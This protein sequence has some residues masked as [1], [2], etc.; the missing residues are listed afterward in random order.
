[1]RLHPKDIKVGD[2]FYECERGMNEKMVCESNPANDG[3][4]WTFDA[5]NEQ[6]RSVNYFYKDSAEAYAP[7][8]YDSPQYA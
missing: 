7:R 3:D 8:L 1:M 4:E 5:T 2:T 6:G